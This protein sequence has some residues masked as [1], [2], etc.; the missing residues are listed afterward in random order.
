MHPRY[1]GMPV[2]T[3]AV[4]LVVF[5]IVDT[6]L[7]VLPMRAG[8]VAWRFGTLGLV[9]RAML[10][11]LLGL[12]LALVA[13]VLLRHR[14]VQ[15]AIAVISGVMLLVMVGAACL[16]ALDA[17]Q[18]RVQVN[19]DAR[20]SLELAS[21]SAVM[22]FGLGIVALAA[23]AYSALRTLRAERPRRAER[24]AIGIASTP[25]VHGMQLAHASSAETG[26]EQRAHLTHAKSAP[27]ASVGNV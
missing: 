25:D 8:E 4:L 18:M 27:P 23:V 1:L 7:G 10:T 19:P 16:F 12:T 20:T 3:V 5:P 15:W 17:V 9:S 2:Y 13:A 22:K 6:G 14:A 11:P 26:A 24:V 21:L